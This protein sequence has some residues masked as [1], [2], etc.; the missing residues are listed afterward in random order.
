MKTLEIETTSLDKEEK[1]IVKKGIEE[2]VIGDYI[3]ARNH[4]L[5]IYNQ[6]SNPRGLQLSIGLCSEKINK[7]RQAR[8]FA[9]KELL[10]YPDNVTARSLLNRESF[11]INGRTVKHD[12]T[13]NER[14][15]KYPDISLV[16]IVKNEEKDLARCLESFK[17][18]VKEMVVVDTGST[19]RTVEIAKSYGAHVEYFEW[20]ED[21][22]AARNESLKYATCEWMLRVDADEYIEEIDKARLL[23]C[24]NSGLAEVYLCP[25]ISP[26]SEGEQIDINVRLMKN[27]L[28]IKF[29]FPIHET[30]LFSIKQAG[31]SQCVANINFQ[32]SGYHYFEPG[33][34]EK[35]TQRNLK[36]CNHYLDL[37][38]NQYY[39]RLVRDLFWLSGPNRDVAIT[40]MEDT[41]KNLPEDAL[42]VRY[43]G[44]TYLVMAQTYINQKRELDLFNLLLDMQIDFNTHSSFIQFIGEIYLYTKGDWKK[45][46]KYFSWNSKNISDNDSY[47]KYL[48]PTKYNQMED[49]LLIAETLVLEKEYAKSQQYFSKARKFYQAKN[50]KNETLKNEIDILENIKKL[51]SL[52]V[53]DLRELAKDQRT[54][55][56]WM[57]AYKSVIRAASKSALTYQDYLDLATCQIKLNNLRFAQALLDEARLLKADSAIVPNLESLIALL[58][59]KNDKALEKAIEAFIKNPNNTG[60]QSNVE[61]ISKLFKLNPVQAIRKVGLKWINEGKK[62]EG[63][64]TLIVYQKFQPDDNEINKI[65]E[66]LS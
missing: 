19:D 29:D 6:D 16:M 52:N 43:L 7:R 61:K 63:L 33:S 38:P 3:N 59:K 26:T 17:D 65:I 40:D 62:T 55:S 54:K 57:K 8:L 11:R 35:K 47:E 37:H 1:S 30:V 25:M 21:F 58:E 5:S 41:I 44:L 20:C 22:A 56:E 60:F 34:N 14:P 23:H 9:F 42:S 13:N 28:G 53:D 50:N 39:V 49:I 48:P 31:L 4:F 2:Y 36:V 45:A 24:L 18:I 51:D 10:D 66:N 46:N 32:H 12:F 64:Y 15:E 27:Y